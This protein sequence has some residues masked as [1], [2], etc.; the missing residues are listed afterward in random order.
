MGTPHKHAELIKAWA[1]G[2]KVQI[3]TIHGRWEN[4]E[5]PMWASNSIYRIKPELKK[6][7]FR[8]YLNHSNQVKCWTSAWSKTQTQTAMDNYFKQWLGPVEER[9]FDV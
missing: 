5:R 1:D 6:V 3:L 4:I 7:Q 9:E 8:F 2:A